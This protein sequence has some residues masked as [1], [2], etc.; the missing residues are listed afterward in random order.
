MLSNRSSIALLLLFVGSLVVVSCSSMQ[1][2]SS[3]Q[4][5][6]DMPT[7]FLDNRPMDPHHIFAAATATAPD[8]Q[9]AASKAESQARGDIAAKIETQFQG[10]SKQFQE[11]VG[12]GPNSDELS[13]FTQAYQSVISQTING[14][15]VVERAIVQENGEYRAYV[16]MRMPIG[17]AQERLMEQLQANQNAFTRFRSSQAFEEL[18]REL[19]G[20]RQ[21][22]SEQQARRDGRTSAQNETAPSDTESTQ[23]TATTEQDDREAASEAEAQNREVEAALTPEEEDGPQADQVQAP[24]ADE[25][26]GA[27]VTEAQA[28]T[29]R[30]RNAVQPW[31]NTPYKLGGESMDGVDCSGLVQALFRDAFNIELPR[32]TGRQ[33]NRGDA[34]PRSEMQ[35]GDL[36]FF[37]TADQQKH[38]GVYLE[39]REFIHASSSQGV[40]ISPLRYD[41]W[42]TNY[43]TARRLDVI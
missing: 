30:L 34:V 26:G 15:E 32:T 5:D 11:E 33:V 2:T 17:Q 27:P 10:L 38:V 6:D 42:Q 13:Q 36:V 24:S 35:P 7:W 18:E 23:G 37:R 25:Q 41:Y 29:S 16:L 4:A 3:Q 22:Q 43:W 31:M 39:D 19:E 21:R 9:L 1:G 8:F 20:Y 28:V 14:S 40:T 12:D